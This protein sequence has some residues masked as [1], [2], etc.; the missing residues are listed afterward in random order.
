MLT[1]PDTFGLAYDMSNTFKI[2]NIIIITEHVWFPIQ[3]AVHDSKIKSNGS[4]QTER[5]RKSGDDFTNFIL[6]PMSICKRIPKYA[7]S[8]LIYSRF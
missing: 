6:P 7:L 2:F 1:T 8:R 3:L 5:K 4:A